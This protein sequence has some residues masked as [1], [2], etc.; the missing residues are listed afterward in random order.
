M[1]Q[2]LNFEIAVLL[3]AVPFDIYAMRPLFPQIM[4]APKELRFWKHMLDGHQ[5]LLICRERS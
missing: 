1:H 5:L 4:E 2:E 3:K